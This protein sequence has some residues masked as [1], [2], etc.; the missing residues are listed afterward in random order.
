ME[1]ITGFL[2][3][4]GISVCILTAMVLSIPGRAGLICTVAPLDLSSLRL[5]TFN[6]FVCCS[7]LAGLFYIHVWYPVVKPQETSE[8]PET[9]DILLTVPETSR[10][11]VQVTSENMTLNF[12]NL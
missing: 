8:L 9:R 4:I 10:V 3:P 7:L 1:T 2:L 12:Q 6:S 11:D 5:E